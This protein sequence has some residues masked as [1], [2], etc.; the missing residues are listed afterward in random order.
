MHPRRRPEPEPEPDD[1]SLPAASRPSN[2]LPVTPI[3]VTPVPV[4]VAPEKPIPNPEVTNC[5]GIISRSGT[6]V[7]MVR[8]WIDRVSTEGMGGRRCDNFDY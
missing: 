4:A 7:D 1:I 6:L 3:P 5:G 2:P 8:R